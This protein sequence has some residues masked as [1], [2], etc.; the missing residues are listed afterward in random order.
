MYGGWHDHVVFYMT[1]LV[2]CAFFHMTKPIDLYE[3]AVFL[4]DLAFVYSHLFLV[5]HQENTSYS[6]WDQIGIQPMPT[7]PPGSCSETGWKAWGLGANLLHRND[8]GVRVSCQFVLLEL[9]L[10]WSGLCT[11]EVVNV[12]AAGRGRL[13]WGRAAL[14]GTRHAIIIVSQLAII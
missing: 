4:H 9:V 11:S 1:S 6:R 12:G 10:V 14:Q 8:L 7:V 13:G 3:P 2:D 5:P